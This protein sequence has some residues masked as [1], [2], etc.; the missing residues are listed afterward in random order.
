MTCERLQQMTKSCPDN[1]VQYFLFYFYFYHSICSR[2]SAPNLFRNASVNSSCAQPLHSPPPPPHHGLLRGIY[3]PFQSRGTGICQTWGSTQ[4][5]ETYAV[6]Y[7]KITTQRILLEKQAYWLYQ[8]QEQIEEGF[9]G[10]FS[11][12]CMNF[13]VASIESNFCWYYVYLNNMLSYLQYKTI[14]HNI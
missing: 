4:A 3:P 2:S 14:G 10:M 12:L 13:F 1:R 5:F 8:G 6:S 11:I 7:Q 9:K